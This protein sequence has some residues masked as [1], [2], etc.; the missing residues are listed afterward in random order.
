ML[1]LLAFVLLLQGPPN[2]LHFQARLSDAGGSP[3]A[4]PVT[5]EVRIYD[6]PLAGVPLW[7][8]T[9]GATALNGVVNLLLG[10]SLALPS[11][12]FNGTDRYLALKVGADPEMTPRRAVASVP[13]ARRAASV[14][15]LDATTSIPAGLIASAHLADGAATAA[16]LSVN[17][18]DSTKIVDGSILTAD[19][20]GGAVTAAKIAN[21]AVGTLQI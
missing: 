15:A 11:A 4:G 19:L 9:H 1:P 14:A 7:S 3:L 17:S 6:V 12:L 2:L 10:S 5:V 20:A 8:E 16:K 18:V 21:G 13:F